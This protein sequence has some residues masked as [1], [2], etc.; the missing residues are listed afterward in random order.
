MLASTMAIDC[1]L[2]GELNCPK[3]LAWRPKDPFWSDSSGCADLQKVSPGHELDAMVIW[4]L[5]GA[6]IGLE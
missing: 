5:F 4:S 6:C 2:L 3:Y 1:I